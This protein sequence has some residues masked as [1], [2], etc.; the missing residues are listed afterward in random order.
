MRTR[1][2]GYGDDADTDSDSDAD[3]DGSEDMKK[4][5]QNIEEREKIKSEQKN[6]EILEKR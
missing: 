3:F 1:I 5:P 6:L 4:L 2:A